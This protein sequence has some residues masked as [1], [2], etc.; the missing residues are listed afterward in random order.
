MDLLIGGL[1]NNGKHVGECSYRLIIPLQTMQSGMSLFES[2]RMEGVNLDCLHR[3]RSEWRDKGAKASHTESASFKASSQ[4]PSITLAL[5]CLTR[6]PT[7]FDGLRVSTVEYCRTACGKSLDITATSPL[8][9]KVVRHCWMRSGV[10]T[11]CMAI[12][13]SGDEHTWIPVIGILTHQHFFAKCFC[14]G[15]KRLC[16]LGMTCSIH[17]FM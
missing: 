10:E 4:K 3:L 5:L 2:P 8:L 17:G 15:R 6:R 13:I 12:W 11:Q 7:G 1:F 9:S 14:Y 16:N